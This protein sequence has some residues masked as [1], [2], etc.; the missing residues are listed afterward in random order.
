MCKSCEQVFITI[1]TFSVNSCKEIWYGVL[2]TIS[3]CSGFLLFLSLILEA[4]IE[5]LIHFCLE[6]AKYAVEYAVKPRDTEVQNLSI[7]SVDPPYFDYFRPHCFCAHYLCCLQL[8]M[9][10]ISNFPS[11]SVIAIRLYIIRLDTYVKSSLTL[12]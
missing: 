9:D 1:L 11:S 2:C 7:T 10:I 3:G 4:L 5:T 8:C 12:N 6:N